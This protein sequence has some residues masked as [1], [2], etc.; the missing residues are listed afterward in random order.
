MWQP[1]ETAPQGTDI[2]LF[3]IDNGEPA[4]AVGSW[5]WLFGD[6][7]ATDFKWFDVAHVRGAD[8]EF[9]LKPTHWAPLPLTPIG[10]SHTG[11]ECIC[12][13]CGLRHGLSARDGGF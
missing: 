4:M 3:G 13:A 6:G 5:A 10:D 12:P 7:R 8:V 11:G 2:L 9:D 1:I